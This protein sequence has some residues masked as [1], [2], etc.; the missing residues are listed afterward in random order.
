MSRSASSLVRPLVLGAALAL[1]CSSSPP[2]GPT[3]AEAPFADR[4]PHAVGVTTRQAGG[5]DVEIWYP[6]EPEAVTGRP[7]ETYDMRVFLPV[8]MQDDIPADAPTTFTTEAVRDV[9]AAPGSF[10]LVYF[11]HGLGGFRLQSSAI[12][13][14]L[15][16][17]GYVVV[18]PEHV[19]RDLAE[20]LDPE[21]MISDAAYTQIIAAH[22]EMI[23]AH[24]RAGDRFEG[25]LDVEY[26]AVMGHSAGTG[27]VQALADDSP[28]GVDAWITMAGAA[29][30]SRST[31]P[32]MVLSGAL[33][34]IARADAVDQLFDRVIST[35][36]RR[37]EIAASGHLAFSDICVIGAEQ[38]GVLR[39]AMN[40][41]LPISDL[42]IQ[43][44]TDGCGPDYLDPAEA[45]PVIGHYAVAHLRD[46]MPGATVPASPSTADGLE[47][48]S[49]ACF[50]TRV[51]R[52]QH[53]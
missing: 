40:A 16:S 11:S 10:P 27:A 14:H 12:C 1:G 22:Q 52:Y 25:V 32:G 31:V 2:A 26:V 18:A 48:A 21:A 49:M 35:P 20:V 53:P 29:A 23:A 46:A 9:D 44:A 24:S 34:N 38:G 37:I 13:A 45:W 17:W 36:K 33:D 4:G 51:S 43:L 42:V 30:P 8:S 6:A 15:A 28:L 3:C 41:G 5:V 50:G 7:L 19:E 47:D 39:I